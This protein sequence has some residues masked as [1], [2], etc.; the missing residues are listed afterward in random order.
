MSCQTGVCEKDTPTERKALGKIAFQST[1]S[2]AG[3]PLLPDGMARAFTKGVFFTDACIAL[4]R[5]VPFRSRSD[6]PARQTD[7]S[8]S[9]SHR[10]SDLG[11]RARKDRR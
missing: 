8:T 7:P 5:V 3:E 4:S 1:E 11:P 6:L 9:G 10:E 2:G